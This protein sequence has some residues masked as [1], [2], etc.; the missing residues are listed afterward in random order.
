MRRSWTADEEECLLN[1]LELHKGSNGKW[2]KDSK[3][4]TKEVMLQLE[5]IKSSGEVFLTQQKIKDKIR[6]LATQIPERRMAKPQTIFLR[7]P[8]ALKL[9]GRL[10]EAVGRTSHDVTAGPSHT[11]EVCRPLVTCWHN[12]KA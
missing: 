2:V 3:K 10:Y 5:A 8:A 1:H 12:E 11:I 4:A 6:T 7:G 9:R